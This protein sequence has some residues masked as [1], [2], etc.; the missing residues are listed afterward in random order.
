[1]SVIVS[2]SLLSADFLHLSKDIEMVNRSQADWFH[3]DIMDGVFVPNISYG[4]PV[5]SQ[6]KKMATKPLDVHLMIVQPERY[7]EAFHKAGADILTVHYET[8]THLHRTIQQ[9]KAQGMKAGVSLNPHTPVSLLEDVIEDIDVV[10]LMS[11]NPGFGGQ[12]FIEQTIN[13][14]DKLKKLIMESNSHTL[15]EIDGGVNF[16][17]GKRLVNAGADALVAGSFVFN[18]PDPEANIK[19]LKEL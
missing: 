2:P 8:C 5:V 3:L 11:V 15:I 6:I 17:T 10:L 16:E 18:S 13:K 7:V 4:L 19:G 12:S 9:I 1:M 14:V